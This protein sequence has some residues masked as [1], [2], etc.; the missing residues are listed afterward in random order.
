MRTTLNLDSRL[1]D[2][3]KRLAA[4]RSVSIGV[5]ISELASKGLEAEHLPKRRVSRARKRGFPVFK[6]PK[7]AQTIGLEQVK[8]E[9]D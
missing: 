9:E 5:I 2:T 6:S 8:Q 3:A 4:S 1:L 7:D